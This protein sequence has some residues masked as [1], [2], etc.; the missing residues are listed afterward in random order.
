[1]MTDLLILFVLL[2]LNGFFALSEMAIVSASKPMLRQRAKQG[3]AR[4]TVALALAEDSG[5][6][7]STVQVGITL[8]GIIAGAYGGATFSA[9]MEPVFASVPP[10]APYADTMA[11]VFVISLITYASVVV[12]ELIPKRI[13]LKHADMLALWV[14]RP[15][16]LI[17]IVCLP[18]VWLLNRTAQMLLVPFGVRS[19][20]ESKITEDEVKAVMAEGAEHGVI[21]AAEHAMLQ[22]IIRLG[23]RDVKSIMTHR[24]EMRSLA[25]EMSE[26][27]VRAQMLSMRH[28]RYPVTR[29]GADQV[30]G[31]LQAHALLGDVWSGGEA[32]IGALLEP[33]V[34]IP[35]HTKCHV[36]LERFR[37][38]KLHMAFI[39][40]EHGE[41]EGLITV[42]DILEA[43]VGIMPSN[44]EGT[45]E[46]M[47][48]QREDGSWLV[49]GTTPIEELQITVGIEAM[50]ADASYDTLAGFL[51]HAME[52]T[53][54]LGDVW[55]AYGHRFEVVDMDGRRVDRVLITKIDSDSGL[56]A[57]S[58]P[59]L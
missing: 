11:F 39:V 30:V 55:D 45:R 9:V 31:V 2:L 20:D 15:M 44:Y 53:P 40:D 58:E 19:S 4:A 35:E 59:V 25:M 34:F 37:Q 36:A 32:S 43:I 6:F 27:E 3:S 26:D 18:L 22:R 14:A 57:L 56:P 47:L 23:E 41:V 29:G 17:S 46:P 49:D 1:M 13:A 50:D 52:R 16:K 10:F 24:M 12:G 8:V 48:K 28:S 21:D 7:L 42:S 38:D 51:M 54:E 33:A 5:A